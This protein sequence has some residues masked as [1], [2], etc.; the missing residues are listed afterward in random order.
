MRTCSR[1]WSFLDPPPALW[2]SPSRHLP[3][4][5]S[6]CALWRRTASRGRAASASGW[7]WPAARCLWSGVQTKL[8]SSECLWTRF[9]ITWPS[10]W[11]PWR[12]SDPPVILWIPTPQSGPL[13]PVIR[14]ITRQEPRTRTLRFSRTETCWMLFKLP[15]FRRTKTLHSSSSFWFRAKLTSDVSLSCELEATPLWLTITK[16][17]LHFLRYKWRL[18]W[19][20]FSRVGRLLNLCQ[21]EWTSDLLN[22][23]Q[24]DSFWLSLL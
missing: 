8:G 2:T 13:P 19:N 24:Y 3:R 17:S 1:S 5:L 21:M 10:S 6:L 4:P 15:S 16:V 23:Y 7:R 12:C 11:R 22:V 9:W 18:F 20:H 14:P